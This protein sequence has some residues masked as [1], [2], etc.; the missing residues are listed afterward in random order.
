MN[1]RLAGANE[2]QKA[3]C[4]VSGFCVF[5]DRSSLRYAVLL[6]IQHQQLLGIFTPTIDSFYDYF[7]LGNI[8]YLLYFIHFS[9]SFIFSISLISSIFSFS[10]LTIS[11]IS[12]ITSSCSSYSSVLR[13]FLVSFCRSIPTEILRSFFTQ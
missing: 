9:I 13:A 10:S 4:S 6:Y 7:N 5:S 2:R 8:V 3:L 1:I 11:S 12:S